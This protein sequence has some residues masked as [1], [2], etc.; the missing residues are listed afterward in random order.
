MFCNQSVLF[1]EHV[2]CSVISVFTKLAL[3]PE[4]RAELYIPFNDGEARDESGNN[5]FVQNDGV[6]VSGGVGYFDGS[7][8]LRVPRFSNSDYGDVLLVR[9]RYKQDTAGTTSSSQALV[10][11]GDCLKPSSLYLAA[12]HQGVHF[13]MRTSTGQSPTSSSRSW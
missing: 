12:D 1:C 2:H 13:G 3:S 10:A 6:K 11:N 8:V 4:C 7:A 9:L 5:N